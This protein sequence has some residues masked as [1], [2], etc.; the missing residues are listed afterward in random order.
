MISKYFSKT[1]I[2][3]LQKVG[4][5]IIP[6]DLEFPAFSK[7]GFIIHVDRIL[8]YLPA[9]ERKNFCHLMILFRFLPKFLLRILFTL[10]DKN[11]KFPWLLGTALR[12]L[13]I[14]VKGVVF[15]L[16]Y[17]MLKEPIPMGEKITQ[18]IKWDAKVER[19]KSDPNASSALP[20]P[21]LQNPNPQD[22]Q[23]IYARA[24]ES[25]KELRM[26]PLAQRLKY[27]T[28]LKEIILAQHESILDRIQADTKKS[29]TD[30]LMSEIFGVLDHLTYLEK[31]AIK[32]L[33]DRKVPTP[34][35]LMGKKSK[36]LFE[37]LG[38]ALIISPW[39]Y[40][41]Y[42]A[43]VP[44]TTAFV[45]GNSIIYKPSEITPLTGLVEELLTQS[46]FHP[47]WIQ[48]VYGD[49]QVGAKLIEPRPDKI[50]FTGSVKTGKAIMTKAAEALIPVELE[51]GGKD[52]MIVFEDV[53]LD[54]AVKG[55]VWGAL[56][57]T[58]QACTSVERLYVQE[59][60]YDEF[61]DK[62]I[63]EIQKVKQQVDHDGSA[64]MGIMTS[65]KQIQII[66]E[67]LEDAIQQGAKVLTGRNWD[68]VSPFIPPIVL[69]NT[70]A[71][72]KINQEETFGPLIPLFKFRDEASVIALGND[73]PF[74]LSAS[75]WT[76]DLD[77]AMR[78]T[79]A[80]ETGNV[81]INNVMLTEGNH[82]LPFGGTKQ[83]GIGRYKGEFGFYCFTNIKSVLV[84][85]NSKKIEANWYPYTPQKYQIFKKMMAGLFGEG[86]RSL[87]RFIINGLKL[88]RYS[89]K[90]G[91]KGRD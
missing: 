40:P 15:T 87:G 82:A 89:N 31:Y 63:L 12:L 20:E 53:N 66:R 83:S 65:S 46:G 30:A 26:L 79:K 90:V 48:V 8:D 88:E 64:D 85:K 41:L 25:K 59:S 1:Q 49:G 50:F 13:D 91:R 86:V 62:L 5:I 60:I 68:Y 9:T 52:P 45:C 22:I 6:G 2:K 32:Q 39:N 67:Q 18:L 23:T 36:I 84:D 42:Q 44:L 51:L 37:P 11:A 71:A 7:T 14:G 43:L 78:V 3:G 27:I 70:T 19:P 72:M 77:R 16:Y 24:K 35:S 69:E 55:A 56:T 74:G 21:N 80:L 34:L 57:N 73:S 75:V 33:R 4:D 29:R 58:G 17:S 54:R 76:A 61:R 28:S 47:H 81:S 38:V 10:T